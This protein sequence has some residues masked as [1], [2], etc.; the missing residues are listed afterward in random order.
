MTSSSDAPEP[1]ADGG[2]NGSSQ[3]GQYYGRPIPYLPIEGYPGKLIAI[4][5]TDGVGRSTQ[6]QLLRE[7]LEVK[8]Y[9]EGETRWTRA[10]PMQPAIAIAVS[11]HT[12]NKLSF[13]TLLYPAHSHLLHTR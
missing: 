6:I 7:W 12:L 4:E 8:G 11:R 2:P 1:I 5:G 9:G 10:V 13:L 3:A